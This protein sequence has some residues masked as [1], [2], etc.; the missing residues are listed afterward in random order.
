VSASPDAGSELRWDERGLIVAVAQDWLT[1]QVRMVAWLNR[2]ALERTLSTGRATFFSRSRQQLW[3][4]GEQSGHALR[5]H[6][7][8]ADCDGDTLLL[9]VEPA[10]P[11]CHTGR[12]SCFFRRIEPD[13]RRI[14]RESEA[15]AF[16]QELERVIHERRSESSEK[17]YTKS[18]FEGGAPKIASKVREEAGELARALES[19]SDDRVT[20]EAADVVY[21]L[22]VGLALRGVDFRSVVA[23]LADRAGISG[24]EEKARRSGPHRA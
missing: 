6:A 1:G 23:A 19:E 9:L 13:G 15:S 10:G 4:K 20:A 7:V 8:Y 17:S 18:L 2:E 12:P 24:H 3:E 5:V 21:H 16:L 14:D 22:L 11:S